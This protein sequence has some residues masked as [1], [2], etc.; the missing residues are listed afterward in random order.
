MK[1]V[2]AEQGTLWHRFKKWRYAE[3]SARVHCK[4][5]FIVRVAELVDE[6][7]LPENAKLCPKCFPGR[8]KK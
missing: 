1:Y 4:L 5:I 3:G 8:S 2:R 7:H 6:E